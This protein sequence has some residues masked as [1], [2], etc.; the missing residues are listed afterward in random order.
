E[1]DRVEGTTLVEEGAQALVDVGIERFVARRIEAVAGDVV[2][3][4]RERRRRRID[5]RHMRRTTGKRGDAEAAGIAVAVEDALETKVANGVGE[6]LPVVALVEVEAGLVTTRD[7]EGE[8][9]AVLVD[10]D[11]G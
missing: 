6:D 11:F 8:A 5:R 3:R 10:L 4:A 9:P 1:D 2:R 7:V